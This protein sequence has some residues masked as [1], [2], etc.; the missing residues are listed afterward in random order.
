MAIYPSTYI[1][2]ATV[3]T[4]AYT[5]AY[6][7]TSLVM[8]RVSGSSPP[9]PGATA[10]ASGTG[11]RRIAQVPL[12]LDSLMGMYLVMAQELDPLLISVLNPHLASIGDWIC[13]SYIDPLVTADTG[14]TTITAA[15]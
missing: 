11:Y 1:D 5:G 13:L 8:S 3:A 12:L 15:G 7:S 14:S 2:Y 10:S 4:D 6:A 9:A